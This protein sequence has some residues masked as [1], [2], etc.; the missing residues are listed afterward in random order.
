MVLALLGTILLQL[1]CNSVY[2]E[3]QEAKNPDSVEPM[4]QFINNH[5]DSE[6]VDSAKLFLRKYKEEL[7]HN[8]NYYITTF[9]RF[10]NYQRESD[11]VI[12]NTD[13]ADV[14][15]IVH[16]YTNGY[17]PMQRSA[18]MIVDPDKGEVLHTIQYDEYENPENEDALCGS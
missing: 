6:Y 15:R 10:D 9:T 3:F 18:A 11:I 7:I 17:N 12:R 8:E 1:S 16:E 14:A 13:G 4:I 2:K 5:P